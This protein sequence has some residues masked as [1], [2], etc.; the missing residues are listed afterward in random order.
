[1]VSHSE[2]GLDEDLNCRYTPNG[3]IRSRVAPGSIVEAVFLGELNLDPR[4][5]SI[6]PNLA[7]DAIVESDGGPWLRVRGTSDLFY[8]FQVGDWESLGECYVRA[9]EQYITPVNNDELLRPQ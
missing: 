7:N 1:M 8:P 9:N 3:E 6:E 5:G 2:D 4:N